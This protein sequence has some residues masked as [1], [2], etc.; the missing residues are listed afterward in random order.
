VSK[1]HS[2]RPAIEDVLEERS[3]LSPGGLTVGV[4]GDS[5]SDE[6]QFAPP[7][8]VH[9][10]SWVEVL[11]ATRAVNFGPFSTRSQGEPR[12]RGFAFDWARDGA[13]SED[14]VYN[15]LPGLTGQVARGE[16]QVAAIF[17]GSNDYGATLNA[18]A[19]DGVPLRAAL[20]TLNQREAQLEANFTASVNALLAA[21]PTSR[22]VVSTLF[23]QGLLPGVPSLLGR[24]EARV[25]LTA[26]NRATAR[27][28]A[29]VRA[30]AAH[31]S[32]VAVVDMAGLA[33]Q[34][35]GEAG[36][37]GAL[38]FGGTTLTLAQ[39]GDNYHDLFLADGIHF[40]TLFQ[41][42]IA[43]SFINAVDAAFG[44]GIPPLT[45]QEIVGFAR[46]IQAESA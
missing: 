3:L 21:S 4:L 12:K 38:R 15:Q 28:N 44:A 41:G 22:V 7:D 18:M 11:A 23:D 9:A 40:G 42:M 30:T 6:Y 34:L 29:L 39:Q 36:H 24:P 45:P 19:G 8:R 32:R 31:N 43:N 2:Y 1:P 33:D 46:H 16:V 13:R 14:M 5:Y 20:A 27:F 26:M 35:T 17:I 10:R 37:R 25:L